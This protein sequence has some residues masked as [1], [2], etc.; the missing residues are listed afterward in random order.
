MERKAHNNNDT[1]R[2]EKAHFCVLLP[3]KISLGSH[4]KAEAYREMKK[5]NDE[6]GKKLLFIHKNLEY[7]KNVK[8][9]RSKSVNI[10]G[11]TQIA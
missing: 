1:N 8:N 3:L 6:G 11:I 5:R 7:V 9:R 2:E 4:N 10:E